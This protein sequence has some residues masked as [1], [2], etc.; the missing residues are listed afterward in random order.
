VAA[1]VLSGMGGKALCAGG[2]V[3]SLYYAK[4]NPS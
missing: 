2:D 4:T 3:K 1:V